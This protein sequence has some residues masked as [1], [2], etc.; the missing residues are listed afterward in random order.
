MTIYHV[1]ATTIHI[2]RDA[3]KNYLADFW[4]KKGGGY[5]NISKKIFDTLATVYASP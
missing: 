3:F 4:A 1:S 5:F 2:L